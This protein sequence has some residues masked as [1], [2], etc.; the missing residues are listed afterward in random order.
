MDNKYGTCHCGKEATAR[1]SDA[2]EIDPV[3]GYMRV[4]VY[5]EPVSLCEEHERKPK[6]LRLDGSEE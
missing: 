3:D 2:K 6:C 1:I 5:G 4:E